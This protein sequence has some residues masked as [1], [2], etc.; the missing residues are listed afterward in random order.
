LVGHF[1]VVWYVKLCF[2]FFLFFCFSTVFLIGI[3]VSDPVGLSGKGGSRAT[4]GVT[5]VIAPGV[6]FG[7]GGALTA[8]LVGANDNF[9]CRWADS[10]I[11]V[12]LVTRVC[13]AF[14]PPLGEASFPLELVGF[15]FVFVLLVMV[16]PRS[17][18][19]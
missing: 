14:S 15:R 8:L 17:F 18:G 19:T 4:S 2:F 7:V 12:V 3:S 10:L 5:V 13:F 6:V 9:V 16:G 1:F 11:P